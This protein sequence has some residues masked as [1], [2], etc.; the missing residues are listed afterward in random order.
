MIIM[1]QE[2]TYLVYYVVENTF[3]DKFANSDVTLGWI[4]YKSIGDLAW[5]L[6]GWSKWVNQSYALFQIDLNMI[7]L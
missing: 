5:P 6:I 1:S 7:R 4:M 3:F 2:G